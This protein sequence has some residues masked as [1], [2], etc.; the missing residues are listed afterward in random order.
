MVNFKISVDYLRVFLQISRILLR[1]LLNYVV[2]CGVDWSMDGIIG[3]RAL[4]ASHSRRR[5]WARNLLHNL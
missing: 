3:A 4:P 5:T 1:R 2:L